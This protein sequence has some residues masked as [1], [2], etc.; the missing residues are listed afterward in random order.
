MLFPNLNSPSVLWKKLDRVND[1]VI[2]NSQIF[3][4]YGAGN[5]CRGVIWTGWGPSPPPPKKKRKE[6]K[7]KEKKKRKKRKKE[8][9][10]GTMNNVKLLYI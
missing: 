5:G 2:V 7:K 9:K 10:K 3:E 8:R 6:E 1:C 4:D